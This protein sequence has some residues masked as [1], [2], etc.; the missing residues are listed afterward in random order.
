MVLKNNGELLYKN[1]KIADDVNHMCDGSDFSVFV[2]NDQT[3]WTFGVNDRGE[4]GNGQ[5]GESSKL[6]MVPTKIME[7]IAEVSTGSNHTLAI[8]TDGTLWEFG[9]NYSGQLGIDVEKKPVVSPFMI[10]T[11]VLKAIGTERYSIILKKDGSLSLIGN[12]KPSQ[13]DIGI[14]FN[15]PPKSVNIV[16]D[17]KLLDSNSTGAF[18]DNNG[19]IQIPVR[20]I[21]ETLGATVDWDSATKKIAI[22]FRD[23]TIVFILE[24]RDYKINGENNIMDTAAT[25]VSGR[26]VVPIRFLVEALGATVDWDKDTNTA[27]I[28]NIK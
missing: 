23:K 12:H 3:L 14:N 28:V 7:G 24:N 9:S 8:K 26:T 2:K 19:R 17:G 4:L 27:Y 5:I 18:I 16:L 1:E 22:T 11:E 6:E 20:Y 10:S 21:S 25:I 15:I 13:I